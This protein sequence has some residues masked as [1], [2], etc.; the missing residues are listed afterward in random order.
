[1]AAISHLGMVMM[2]RMETD[3]QCLGGQGICGV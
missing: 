2:P 3:K 1:M